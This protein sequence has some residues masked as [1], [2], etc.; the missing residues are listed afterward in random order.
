MKMLINGRAGFIRSAIIRHIVNNT[1]NKVLDF[2]KLTYLGDLESLVDINK[3]FN[4]IFC[5]NY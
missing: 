5:R 2:D 4:L 1:D 3:S